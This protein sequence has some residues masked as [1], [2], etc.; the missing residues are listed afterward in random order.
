MARQK[1]GFG[2]PLRVFGAVSGAIYPAEPT[3]HR[4]VLLKLLLMDLSSSQVLAGSN[5]APV[6]FVKATPL[7]Q[8]VWGCGFS[9]IYDVSALDFAIHGKPSAENSVI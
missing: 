1:P 6:Q 2:G 7:G 5:N 8:A 3:L 4:R 9:T